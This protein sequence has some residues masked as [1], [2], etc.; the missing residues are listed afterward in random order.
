MWVI[1]Y[2]PPHKNCYSLKELDCCFDWIYTLPPHTGLCA[3][4]LHPSCRCTLGNSGH[5]R[6]WGPDSRSRPL[7][8]C[9]LGLYLAFCSFFFL[10]FSLSLPLCSKTSDLFKVTFCVW[11][12]D[13]ASMTFNFTSGS[14]HTTTT[15]WNLRLKQ[16]SFFLSCYLQCVPVS[17]SDEPQISKS[18]SHSQWTRV[19]RTPC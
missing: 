10:S 15:H 11:S 14:N 16:A 2:L 13:L 6:R 1:P 5:F 12:H 8:A 9:L 19:S 4:G 17:K 7:G 18:L 3:D